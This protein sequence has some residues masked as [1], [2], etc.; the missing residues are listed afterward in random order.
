MKVVVYETGV[1]ENNDSFGKEN[2]IEV[3]KQDNKISADLMTK[4]KKYTT[5]INRFFK[6]LVNFPELQDY[7]EDVTESCRSGYSTFR[8]IESGFAF[9]VEQYED[10]YY[11]SLVATI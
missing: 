6:G 3:V 8:C 4:C 11:I 2:V 9:T 5:A 7:R 10:L 1:I